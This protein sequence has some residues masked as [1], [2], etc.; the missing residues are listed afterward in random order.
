MIIDKGMARFRIFKN[1]SLGN[2]K[3]TRETK[4]ES[5]HQRHFQQPD[6]FS[7]IPL[8]LFKLFEPLSCQSADSRDEMNKLLQDVKDIQDSI[9]E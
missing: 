5:F 8:K 3:T 7:T 1:E 4:C 9:D 6:L 2:S